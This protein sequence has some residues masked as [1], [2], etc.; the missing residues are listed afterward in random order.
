M[1]YRRSEL[2]PVIRRAIKRR[3]LS[4]NRKCRMIWD[5]T[6]FRGDTFLFG[7]FC[8]NRDRLIVTIAVNCSGIIGGFLPIEMGSLWIRELAYHEQRI[9]NGQ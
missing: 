7:S 9:Q 8:I 3:E 5:F 4:L 2:N 6:N 1:Q